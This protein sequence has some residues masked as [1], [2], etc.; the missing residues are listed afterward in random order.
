MTVH[1]LRALYC[2]S[3]HVGEAALRPLEAHTHKQWLVTRGSY[4]RK[5]TAQI[6]P[7]L[8]RCLVPLRKE[9]CTSPYSTEI[10]LQVLTD[11]L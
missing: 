1:E 3:V 4:M 9:I 7:R 8:I 11:E 2:V 10:I 5:Q 6:R